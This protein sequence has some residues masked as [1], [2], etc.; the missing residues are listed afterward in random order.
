MEKGTIT[1]LDQICAF[2]GLAPEDVAELLRQ[3]AEHDIRVVTD[4]TS[5]GW[6]ADPAII[7]TDVRDSTTDASSVRELLA[8]GWQIVRLDNEHTPTDEGAVYIAERWTP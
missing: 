2:L 5:H 8:D 1:A 4:T 7:G 6:G 3:W